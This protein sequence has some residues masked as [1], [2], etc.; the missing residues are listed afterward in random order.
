MF[1]SFSPPYRI[2]YSNVCTAKAI[3]RYVHLRREEEKTAES[4]VDPS[5]RDI[6]EGI[7]KRCLDGREYKQVCSAYCIK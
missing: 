6:I 3:D 4:K 5:L 2:R 1:V 7:F